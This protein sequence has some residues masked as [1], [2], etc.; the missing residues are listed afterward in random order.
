[1]NIEINF[2]ERTV[3]YDSTIVQVKQTDEGL[4]ITSKPIIGSN[5]TLSFSDVQEFVEGF[6]DTVKVKGV[7]NCPYYNPD[8]SPYVPENIITIQKWLRGCVSRERLE[9]SI[10]THLD[11]RMGIASFV[12]TKISDSHN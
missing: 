12:V 8:N 2:K 4:I 10:D 6:K 3:K 11:K 1:M 7:L 9:V 5:D